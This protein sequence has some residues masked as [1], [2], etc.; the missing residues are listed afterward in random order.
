L[1]RVKRGGFEGRR[2]ENY[3]QKKK[4]KRGVVEEGE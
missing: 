1:R 3:E 2:K 4:I